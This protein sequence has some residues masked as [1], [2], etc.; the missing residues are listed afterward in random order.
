MVIQ[1]TGTPSASGDSTSS[2]GISINF[3]GELEEDTGGFVGDDVTWTVTVDISDD[4]DQ[5]MTIDITLPDE[6]EIAQINC[7]YSEISQSSRITTIT[8]PSMDADS[9]MTCTIETIIIIRD[10]DSILTGLAEI[11]GYDLHAI[12]TVRVLPPV[13]ALP[14]TGETPWAR[15][16]LVI[17]LMVLSIV[18]VIVTGVYSSKRHQIR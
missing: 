11:N 10:L 16:P 8:I 5:P 13:N 6:V 15:I 2:D 1:F 9:T 4:N 7:A 3:V 18:G 14:Q 12:A 17:S